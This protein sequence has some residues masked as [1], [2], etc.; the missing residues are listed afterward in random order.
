MRRIL[1]M[2]LPVLA[3]AAQPAQAGQNVALCLAIQKNFN[4]CQNRQN[5]KRRHW[6]RQRYWEYEEW[7]EEGP[8]WGRE[9]PPD[10]NCA[11]WIVALKANQCF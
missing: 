6:E 11:A 4:D 7:G 2:T 1:L 9:G 10:E 8:P 3:L 5:H